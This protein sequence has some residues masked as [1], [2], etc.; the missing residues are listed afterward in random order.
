MKLRVPHTFLEGVFI[1]AYTIG[2]YRAFIYLRGEYLTEYE[3]LSGLSE[4]DEVV[5]SDM[6]D[7]ER[8]RELPIR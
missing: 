1:A 7:Y 8:S 2:S 3:V 6:R 5:I 4:G